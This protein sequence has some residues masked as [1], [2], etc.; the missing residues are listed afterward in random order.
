MSIFHKEKMPEPDL[1][2]EENV[3]RTLREQR[4]L[5]A[6]AAKM[7]GK[8]KRS[9]P[10]L[11]FGWSFQIL[12]VIL[13]AYVIVYFFGQSRTNVGQSMDVTL[14]GGDTVLINVMAY[15]L[16]GPKRG[17]VISFKLNGTQTSHSNI[18][19]VIGLPGET[20][21]IMD[22]MIYIDGKVYLEQ[23]NYPAISNPGMAAEAITLGSSEYFVLGDNRNNSEDSRFADV[24]LVKTDDIE[25]KVWFVLSPGEHRRFLG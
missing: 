11:V 20:V 14:S 21:Q 8:K 2:P 15:Q 6:E 1:F 18:K 4:R 22:G 7:T 25:G 16:G 17:D 5:D 23:K 3:A 10:K 19:R 9:I 12:I 24:G 13:I